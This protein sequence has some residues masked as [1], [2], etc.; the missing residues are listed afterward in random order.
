M[1][2]SKFECYLL[3]VST[4]ANAVEQDNSGSHDI[5]LMISEMLDERSLKEINPNQCF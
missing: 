3:L 4:K 1:K 5:R 2:D